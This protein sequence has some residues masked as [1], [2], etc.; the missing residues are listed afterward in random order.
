MYTG[1]V[2]FNYHCR[3][4][5]LSWICGNWVSVCTSLGRTFLRTTLSEHRSCIYSMI[6]TA[7]QSGQIA[8]LIHALLHMWRTQTWTNELVKL[9]YTRPF[10]RRQKLC[11]PNSYYCCLRREQWLTAMGVLC[12]NPFNLDR[13]LIVRK[14]PF[15]WIF[16]C[17]SALNVNRLTICNHIP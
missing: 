3:D 6:R 5:D 7:S 13:W 11:E 17:M 2:V 15:I 14:N 9:S 8:S 4:S 1:S 10:R 12:S 16:A